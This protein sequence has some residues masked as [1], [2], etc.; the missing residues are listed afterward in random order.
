MRILVLKELQKQRNA[1]SLSELELLFDK[2]DRVTLFRTLKTFQEHRLIHHIDDGTGV[3]KYAL[4][5]N[6][7]DCNPDE[8]HVH[9]RC[10]KCCKTYCLAEVA[11]P[12]I[13][14]PVNFKLNEVNILMKGLCDKCAC[15]LS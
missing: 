3:T 2:A 6:E 10:E 1:I 8:L 15:S 12:K 14:L 5:G 4:C 13:N 9:F 11:I 7:C